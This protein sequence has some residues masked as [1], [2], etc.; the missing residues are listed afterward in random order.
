VLAPPLHTLAA[1][2]SN[3]LVFMLAYVLPKAAG[4]GPPAK[5]T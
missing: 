4:E 1:S 5:R 3:A 2:P